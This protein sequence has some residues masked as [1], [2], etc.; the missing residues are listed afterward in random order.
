[1]NR[2]PASQQLKPP[3]LIP[4]LIAGFNTVTN[5]LGLILFPV[6]LDLI[7]W[8][9][10]QLKLEKYFSPIYAR[11]FQTLMAYNNA[12]MQNLLA[13][14]QSDLDVFL[15]KI[16]LTS[17]L[18]TFPIGVPSLLSGRGVNENPIGT[19]IIYELPSLGT[20]FL[21]TSLFI[22]FG[23]LLG[24]IYLHSIAY[25]TNEKNE[26][27]YFYGIVKKITNSM[28]LSILLV[29][30]IVIII[31]PVLFITS[32][33]AIISPI[34]AQAIF[35]IFSIGFI[36]LLIPLVFSPHGIFLNNQSIIQ[37]ITHSIRVVRTYLPGTG[38]FLLAAIIIAQG[39]DILWSAA[40]SSSWLTLV[41]ITGHA[42]IYTAL[43]SAS[44]FY[45]QKTEAW[46]K[47]L[48]IKVKSLKK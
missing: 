43:I 22:A 3:G 13:A 8:F 38:F 39:L 15:T 32:F 25:K 42:F 24:S 44:F 23:L 7:I 29:L 6:I 21:V 20:I 11:L 18:S 41:G 1:M 45:Y 34:A 12:E 9:G 14:S 37:S 35:F 48:L 10:P 31:V 4:S 28:I 27:S 17:S 16:N 40:P 33:M 30:L 36:W 19:A 26:N 47:D 2:K 5:N 46:A